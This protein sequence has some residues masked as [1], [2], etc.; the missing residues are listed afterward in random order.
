MSGP[1]VTSPDFPTASR[2]ALNDPQLR[3]NFRR[4]M[5]GLVAK[6]AVQFADDAEWRAMRSLGASVR[7]RSLAK[8]PELL[9][10]LEAN[11]QR[12]GIQ[13]HWAS[14]TDEAN[15]IILRLVQAEN[16][17]L[18]VKGKSMVTEEMRL[19]A[20]LEA[21]GIECVETDL[22]EYIVQL[23]GAMPS[24]IVMPAIH[25]SR[26][27]IAHLFRE[28]IRDA[29]Y[30][31]D[32]DQL[33]AL[34]RRIL[35]RKFQT[36]GVG[37]SGVNVAVAETG[38]L[39]LIE[40]EGNGRMS[41]TVPPVHIA[42]MGL[43]KVVERLED[44]APILSLLPRSATAQ[45]I[46]TYVNM[47]THPR[48]DGEKDGPRAVHLVILD[49][50]RSAIHS[51]PER[52]DTLRCIRC[53]TCMNHCPVYSRIGGH[54]Y[55]AP[56]PG[57][58]GQILMPQIEGLKP[59]GDLPHACTMCNACVEVCPVKIPIVAITG[60]LRQAAANA[61]PDAGL[62]GIGS[63]RNRR[64]DL[65]WALWSRV[66]SNPAAHRLASRLLRLVLPLAPGGLPLLRRWTA[67]RARPRL[68]PRNLHELVRQRG[69]PDE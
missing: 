9:E 63:H 20:H 14:T 68:A 56:Y 27:Q 29:D 5:D 18:V 23:D 2:A 50:G 8:L 37:I 44:V 19:N 16:T 67:V 21:H 12:N 1:A 28:R 54:A 4:A 33:T 36:A 34:A 47:I 69:I 58:L 10:K 24:H 40:N 26:Q 61:G 64:E 53:G 32:V 49:N 17:R 35:R 38:T 66:M 41:T 13:V 31:E 22:G 57:P 6:R 55:Q 51:A 11:C 52:R 62:R 15:A 39:C 25:M 48:R 3:A 7:Q 30:T 45:P 60:E 46:T 42:V 43:E 65:V 59:R